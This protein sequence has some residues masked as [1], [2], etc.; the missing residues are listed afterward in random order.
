MLGLIDIKSI[1][2]CVV[3]S[4]YCRVFMKGPLWLFYSYLKLRLLIVPDKKH[5]VKNYVK[6]FDKEPDLKDPKTINEFINYRKLY[7]R[8]PLYTLCSDK[9]KVREYVKDKIGEQYLIPLLASSKDAYELN[10]HSLP[11]KFVAKV[12]HGS[13]QNMIVLDKSKEDLE[14]MQVMFC[15]WMKRN[16]YYN[17]REW[18][19]KDIEP[20]LIVEELLSDESGNVPKDYKFH[21][22]NGKVEMIQLDTERFSDHRR[23]FYSPSWEELDFMWVPV[24]ENG[25]EKYKKAPTQEKPDNLEKMIEIVEKLAEDFKYVR[26]DL[27][28]FNSKI[29]FGELT[30]THEDGLAKFFPEKYDAYYGGKLTENP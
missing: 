9:Y 30:F 19:Y 14:A 5:I 18:Q 28:N 8:N 7:D 4:K 25:E 16:H 13:G 24:D 29:Y 17:T 11:D 2:D 27:Y 6:V 26:V 20:V 22:I 21:T 3:K 15:Y 10:F 23:I 1:K 12:N